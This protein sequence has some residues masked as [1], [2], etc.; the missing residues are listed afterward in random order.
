MEGDSPSSSAS[1]GGGDEINDS[2][3]W[4]ST[5]VGAT[6]KRGGYL[7]LEKANTKS[8]SDFWSAKS[9]L[10]RCFVRPYLL[11]T[12]GPFLYSLGRRLT[13]CA[14][15]HIWLVSEATMSC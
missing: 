6:E 13:S 3:A 2:I 11:P 7:K 10:Y 1:E 12:S 14:G 15:Q 4:S 8:A 9:F 5:T